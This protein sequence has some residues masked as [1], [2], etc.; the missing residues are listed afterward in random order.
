MPRPQ[1]SEEMSVQ[2]CTRPASCSDKF[3]DSNL[4]FL[5]VIWGNQYRAQLEKFCLIHWEVMSRA[6]ESGK[7][8]WAVGSGWSG[9]SLVYNATNVCWP[10]ARRW[11]AQV[12]QRPRLLFFLLV[13]SCLWLTALRCQISQS[14]P[15]PPPFQWVWET[16][17]SSIDGKF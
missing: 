10:V 14:H 15:P 1:P 17:N 3:V 8:D 16:K 12:L 7:W 5:R 9:V 6:C 11:T 2:C 13:W 4:N